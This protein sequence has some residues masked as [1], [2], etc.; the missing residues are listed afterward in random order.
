[1]FED[2]DKDEDE[3]P[4]TYAEYQKIQEQMR[5]GSIV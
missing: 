3:P 2:K 5:S 1:M 4:P